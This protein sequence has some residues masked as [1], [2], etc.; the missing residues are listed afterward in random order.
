MKPKQLFESKTFCPAPWNNLYVGP[1]GDVK[2]CSI[3]KCPTGNLNTDTFESCIKNNPVLKE[4]QGAMINGKYHSNCAEC[5][6]LETEQDAYSLR[7]HYKRTLTRTDALES[8]DTNNGDLI[9]TGFDLR[10][11]NT[12]QNAC[13]YCFPALSSRWAKELGV[14]VNRA[15][16]VEDVK[17][18]V[19]DNLANAKEVYLAGGEPL[20]NKDFAQLLETLYEVN[21]DCKL[22]INSNIKNIHTPVFELSKKFK[23]L[24]YTISAESIGE[25]YQYIRYPQTWSSFAKNVDVVINEVPSYNFNMVLN[26]L[27]P[28]ALFD[29]IDYLMEKGVHENGFVIHH[30]TS[31]RWSNINNLPDNQLEKF[32]DRCTQLQKTLDP[33]YSLYNAVEGCINFI[34]FK[35]KKDI[36]DTKRN[37]LLLDQRRKLNSKELF[38]HIWKSNMEK[39]ET[40]IPV[41]M[42]NNKQQKKEAED[43]GED[44]DWAET[45][46]VNTEDFISPKKT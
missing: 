33:K 30:A 34:D 27:N 3:G 37:L 5:Y 17:Q 11:D 7:K 1:D 35:Y 25:H 41:D 16:G 26:V 42:F 31:P 22:R 36:E 45:Y 24:R 12:C 18:F 38:P 32:V 20:I 29:C 43:Q 13:V 4:I 44:L 39:E 15:D 46:G 28:V 10:Y 21:P 9:P 23:K 6:K 14:T 2:T 40:I 19:L 8:Y